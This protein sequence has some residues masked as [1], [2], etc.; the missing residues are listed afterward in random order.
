[1]IWRVVIGCLLV[2]DIILVYRIV[3]PEIGIPAY[4]RL[5]ERTYDCEKK[6]HQMDAENRDLSVEIR[7]LRED[8]QYVRRLIRRELLYAE[9]NEIMYILK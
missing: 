8:E 5:R 6:I 3:H 7:A 4:R 9:E 2:L 1:M